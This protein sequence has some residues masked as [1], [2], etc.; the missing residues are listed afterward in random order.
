MG[1]LKQ[2]PVR[3]HHAAMGGVVGALSV[4]IFASASN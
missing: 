4:D 3:H 1:Q 2:F